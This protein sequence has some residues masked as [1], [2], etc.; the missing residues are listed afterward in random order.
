MRRVAE[1]HRLDEIQRA[2]G[3]DLGGPLDPVIAREH[4]VHLRQEDRRSP[5]RGHQNYDQ[6]GADQGEAAF[7]T[8][9]RRSVA[10]GGPFSPRQGPAIGAFDN[11]CSNHA[12][13]HRFQGITTLETEE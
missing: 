2:I 13:R 12:L 7:G 11:A 8:R 10:M 9:R 4:Q 3:G 1:D 5:E 6:E